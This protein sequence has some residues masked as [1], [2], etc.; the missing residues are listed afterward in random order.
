MGEAPD[1]AKHWRGFRFVR[2]IKNT[3]GDRVIDE[4][5]SAV[6]LQSTLDLATSA[7]SLF[8]FGDP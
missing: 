3:G 7:L 2:L 6:G 4:V 8:A 1:L 5:R